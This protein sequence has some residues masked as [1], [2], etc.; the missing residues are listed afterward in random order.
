MTRLEK[1]LANHADLLAAD[2]WEP[3]AVPPVRELLAAAGGAGLFRTAELDDAVRL[4][5]ALAHTG[6]GAAGAAMLTHTEVA[7]RLLAGLPAAPPA[8]VEALR[9]GTQTAS[10][11]ATEPGGGSDL[12]NLATT[13]DARLTVTGEKWFISNAPY[14]DHLVV[15][16]GDP[17]GAT[18]RSG[19]ALLLV[20]VA[21]PGVTVTPLD[22]AGHPGLTGRI[23]LREAAVEAVLAPG[24]HG[25]LILGKHW[26]H[27]RVLLAV[28]MA[29]LAAAVL[30]RAVQ[31]TSGRHTFGAPLIANQHVRFV[32]A[33]LFAEVEEVRALVRQGVRLLGNG[34]CPPA[35]AAACKQRAAVVLRRVADRAIQLAGADGYCTGHPAE[36]ALRDALGLAL[37]GGPD[38]LMLTQIER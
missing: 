21:G 36:R 34:A 9:D 19:P 28:R 22:T 18:G 37:A 3:P 8:L 35:Y 17:D 29:E 31:D 13:V 7:T 20:P 6:N 16:A 5:T 23:T 4:H 26:I 33:E 25:L 27:E 15:L 2:A 38:E 1:F 24:G 10:L 30:D 14:A 32:L 11:A 12:T